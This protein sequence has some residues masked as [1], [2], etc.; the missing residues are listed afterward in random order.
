MTIQQVKNESFVLCKKKNRQ[1]RLCIIWSLLQ[2]VERL[3]PRDM[4]YSVRDC[5]NFQT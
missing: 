2:R 1:T 3:E 4:H 5:T